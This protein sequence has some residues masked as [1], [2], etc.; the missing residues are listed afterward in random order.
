MQVLAVLAYLV[1]VG[2]LVPLG[3]ALDDQLP[4]VAVAGVVL[5]AFGIHYTRAQHVACAAARQAGAQN[6]PVLLPLLL[7][8][9]L[10]IAQAFAV[11]FLKLQLEG[12]F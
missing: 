3:F 8:L 4:L 10:L 9:I 6:A 2:V 11:W 5:L 7:G 1:L 12:P